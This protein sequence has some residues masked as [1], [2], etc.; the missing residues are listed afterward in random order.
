MTVGIRAEAQTSSQ[1]T[2][3]DTKEGYTKMEFVEERLAWLEEKADKWAELQVIVHEQ[4]E[5]IVKLMADR[6][7]LREQLQFVKE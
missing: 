4:A 6:D 2:R 1:A 7:A 3:V 5:Q